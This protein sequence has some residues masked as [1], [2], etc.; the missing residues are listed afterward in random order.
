MPA[1]LLEI[2]LILIVF[3][4]LGPRRIANLFRSLGTG[5]HDFIETLGTG[6]DKEELPDKDDEK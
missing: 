4:V 3:L 1:G 5:V 6:K 2:L